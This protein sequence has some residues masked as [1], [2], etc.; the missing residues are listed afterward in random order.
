MDQKLNHS[1]TNERLLVGRIANFV[2]TW[3]AEFN[4]CERE[5]SRVAMDT[6][7]GEAPNYTL[8]HLIAI[9]ISKET[10]KGLETFF[11]LGMSSEHVI[12]V[13]VSGEI[14]YLTSKRLLELLTLANENCDDG[15]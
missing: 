14:F 2:K 11:D 8:E 5:L 4:L 7:F 10:S 12:N 13:T 15:K 6:F 3:I 1:T 9:E